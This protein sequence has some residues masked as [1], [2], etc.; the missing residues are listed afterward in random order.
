MS[1]CHYDTTLLAKLK[2]VNYHSTFAVPII[3]S[4]LEAPKKG[5]VA[6]LTHILVLILGPPKNPI[7]SV[8]NIFQDF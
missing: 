3:L 1:A 8:S 2:E 6:I 7:L 4:S 5:D